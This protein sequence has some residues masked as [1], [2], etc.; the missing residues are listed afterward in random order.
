[1]HPMISA[2]LSYID[3]APSGLRI[4]ALLTILIG[5]HLAVL[6][7]RRLGNAL[8]SSYFGSQFAK[9]RTVTGLVTSLAVFVLYFSGFGLIVREFGVSLQ[10][11]FTSASVMGLAVGF[12]LQGLVQDVVMGLTLVFSDIV[13]VGDMVE[14]TID[15]EAILESS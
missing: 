14:I 8:M 4:V 12:G 13:D 10:A 15:A 3:S 6:L 1:M 9:T 2:V 11:Y 5:V 7:V